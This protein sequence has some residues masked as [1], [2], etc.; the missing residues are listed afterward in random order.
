MIQV[1]KITPQVVEHFD[2]DNNSLGFLNYEEHLDLRVQI[3]KEQIFGY[4]LVFND[5]KIRLDLNGECEDYPIGLY[6]TITNYLF[7]LI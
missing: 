4:Y 2:P 7:Q 6:E 1:N 5:K 3:K